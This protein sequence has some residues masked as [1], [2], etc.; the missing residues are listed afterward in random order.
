[1]RKQA[2][3]YSVVLE[4]QKLNHFFINFAVPFIYTHGMYL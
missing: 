1:M 3:D 4:K 2:V